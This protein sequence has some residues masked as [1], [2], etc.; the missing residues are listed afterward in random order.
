MFGVLLLDDKTGY[1]MDAIVDE[2]RGK[3]QRIVRSILKRWLK[4][5]GKPVT[6]QA[7]IDTLR[8]CKQTALADRIQNC[9]YIYTYVGDGL[10][11]SCIVRV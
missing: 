6:W 7:L 5:K 3:P 11:W 9:K 4:G 10:S 8:T 2:C 1:L